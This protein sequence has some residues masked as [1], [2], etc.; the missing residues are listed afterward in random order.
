MRTT[1]SLKTQATYLLLGNIV[2]FLI[3]GVSPIIM[4]RLMSTDQYGTYRQVLFISAL[5]VVLIRF[6][7]PKSLYY[8]FP[9][10]SGNLRV[11]FSQSIS[12][13]F[14]LSSVGAI[15]FYIL[16]RY[17]HFLPSGV[18]VDYVALIT[19]YILIESMAYILD[20]IFILEKK[21]R[22]AFVL[23]TSNATLRL[24]LVVGAILLFQ[25]VIG[26]LY[27]LI[28]LSSFRLI[29]LIGYLIKRYGLRFGIFDRKFLSEQFRY[30]M[31]LAATGII[32]LVGRDIDKGIIGALMTPIDFA[33][34]SIGGLGIIGAVNLLYTSTG[35][36]CFQR[37][38]E[39]AMDKNMEGIRSLWHKMVVANALV[40]V[41]MV[42]FCYTFAEQIITLLFTEKYLLSANIWRI[43]MMVLL[44]KMAGHG[45]IPMALGKTRAIL[46]ANIIRF[47]LIVPLSFLLITKFGILGGAIAFVSGFWLNAII[48]LY[49]GKRALNVTISKFFPWRRVMSI[50]I[51]CAIPALLM[52]YIANLG[53]SNVSTLIVG[54]LIYFTVIVII[55][56]L[57][58][59]INISDLK[60]ILRPS[61]I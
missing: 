35:N 30:T 28:L 46:T 38:G 24:S 42:F 25:S 10:M 48:Q 54:G 61:I 55:Y 22:H 4:V 19:I 1:Y 11:L 31:P 21:P 43:N 14:L 41:P 33:I 34:Y 3:L 47:V 50:F 51:I 23:T 27:V 29:I 9:R 13:L 59:Y 32:G 8:F 57:L 56:K 37:F 17:F 12:V 16:G 36:I 6:S 26:I 52:L 5:A 2:A 18:T 44:I 7:I 60:S 40:T 49:I 39:L 53:M 58:G 45:Y 15:I 20:H